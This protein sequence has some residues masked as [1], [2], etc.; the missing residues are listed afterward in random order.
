VIMLVGAFAMKLAVALRAAV[1][2][3][4]HSCRRGYAQLVQ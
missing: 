2:R 1:Y 4:T 3:R